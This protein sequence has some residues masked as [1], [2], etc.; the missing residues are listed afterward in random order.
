MNSDRIKE[1]QKETFY[2][3]SVSVQQALLKVWN[4]CKQ[5]QIKERSKKW[6]TNSTKDFFE[7]STW[8]LYLSLTPLSFPKNFT[9][10]NPDKTLETNPFSLSK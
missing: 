7:S 4:E 6:K 2:P 1:I 8:E 5:E 9:D 10:S 3:E